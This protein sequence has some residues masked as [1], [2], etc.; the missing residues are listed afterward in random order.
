MMHPTDRT[1]LFFGSATAELLHFGGIGDI[2]DFVVR[3]QVFGWPGGYLD[4]PLSFSNNN[5][6]DIINGGGGVEDIAGGATLI[7]TGEAYLPVSFHSET[8]NPPGPD[9]SMTL[10]TQDG[11]VQFTAN[12]EA[13][14]S[15]TIYPQ[16]KQLMEQNRLFL[17]VVR[18]W[19]SIVNSTG[20]T[21][22]LIY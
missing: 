13:G 19:N 8:N 3:V 15:Q 7:Y 5:D 2:S 18:M 14:Q 6:D 9:T 10:S 4:I 21:R 20:G 16:F 17:R 1:A 22:M 12:D 11:F